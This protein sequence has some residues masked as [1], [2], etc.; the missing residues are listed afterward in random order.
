MAL[1]HELIMYIDN[2][3]DDKRFAHLNGISDLAK[4]M[5][6]TRK[7][8]SYPLIYR[9]L[10]LTLVLPVATATVEMCFSAMKLVKSDLRNQIGD[11][12][13]SDCLVSAIEKEAFANVSNDDV[14]NHF[15]KMKTHMERL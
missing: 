6:Q 13:L 3:K 10:K 5:V 4:L 8:L 11:V 15:Q 12:F 2:V 14:I 9:L 1:E 7:H